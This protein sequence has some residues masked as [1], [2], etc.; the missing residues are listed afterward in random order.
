MT[1][2]RFAPRGLCTLTGCGKPWTASKGSKDSTAHRFPRALGK[3]A[4]GRRFPTAHTGR[5]ASLRPAKEDAL[6]STP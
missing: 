2:R 6:N 3:P 4:D 1:G 5:G